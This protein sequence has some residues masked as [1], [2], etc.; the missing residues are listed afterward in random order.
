MSRQRPPAVVAELGRPE[1]PEEYAAR[2]AE[3]SR[4]RRSRQTTKNLWLSILASLAVVLGLVLI[5]P[6]GDATYAPHVDYPAV[7]KEAQG[8]VDV[9]LAVPAL[10][11]GWRSNS[12]ELREGADDV[13]SWY[14]GLL[15]PEDDYLGFSQ[16][17]HAN[18][19]WLSALLGGS[20]ADS[21][22]R[23]GGLEWTVYDNRKSGAKG[24]VEYALTTTTEDSIYAVYG[25]ADPAEA[26]TLAAAVA[27][28]IESAA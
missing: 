24:N 7:A 16:G 26:A 25:T 28:S 18:E 11:D 10:P 13:K 22:K 1:T 5:V 27:T 4:L 2:R 23:I 12:A 20:R 9:P 15:T 6:R 21:T 19:S 14:V 17:I 8:A 3:A